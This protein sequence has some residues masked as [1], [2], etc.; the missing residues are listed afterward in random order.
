MG[1]NPTLSARIAAGG[2]AGSGHDAVAD[3]AGTGRYS[4]SRTHTMPPS[5]PFTRRRIAPTCV[6][7]ELGQPKRMRKNRTIG[8]NTSGPTRPTLKQVVLRANGL[9]DNY[10]EDRSVFNRKPPEVPQADLI[11]LLLDAD[12]P[13]RKL[14]VFQALQTGTLR[15]SEAEEVMAQVMRLE[16]VAAP[17]DPKPK[18]GQQAA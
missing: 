9:G 1:S 10:M 15:K 13:T 6:L 11:D 12:E 5:G 8:E 4:A 7:A 3:A 14:L 16:R 2:H 17:R 18:S